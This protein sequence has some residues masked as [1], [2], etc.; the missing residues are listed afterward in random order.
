MEKMGYT[1]HEVE[2]AAEEEGYEEI[3]ATYLLLGRKDIP[4][5]GVSKKE[6]LS[7]GAA[8]VQWMTTT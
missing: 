7:L 6:E 4:V 8:C 5:C 3:M 1:R 2:R